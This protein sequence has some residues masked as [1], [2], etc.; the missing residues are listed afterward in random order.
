MDME[1]GRTHVLLLERLVELSNTFQSSA[2][3][4]AASGS[5]DAA[6]INTF[7]A[8]M[9]ERLGVLNPFILN[10]QLSTGQ[11]EEL[12]RVILGGAVEA[13]R[14]YRSDREQFEGL[15][16]QDLQMA[17]IDFTVL[18]VAIYLAGIARV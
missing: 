5:M 2:E 3:I 8:L 4:K 18:P 12:Q 11:S 10:T 9:C 16:D 15:S 1:Y 7:A 17:V 14:L 6:Q 13:T